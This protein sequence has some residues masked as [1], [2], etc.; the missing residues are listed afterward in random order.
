MRICIFTDSFLP[1]CSGVTFAIINQARELMS[2]GHEVA[3]FRPRPNNRSL[4]EEAGTELPLPVYNVPLS[5]SVP[6][7]PK[8]RLGVPTVITS[9]RELRK[10]KPD[11]IHVASEWGCGWEGVLCAKLLGVPVVGT[12]HT[13]FADPGYLK[14]I[15]LPSWRPLCK[16]MW[17]YSTFFYNRCQFV[18]SPSKAV[19]EALTNQGLREPPIQISNGIQPPPEVWQTEIDA[20]RARYPSEG[21]RFVYIGR[22]S[23]EKSLDILLKGFRGV[24]DRHP[25]ATLFIVGNGPYLEEMEPMLDELTLRENVRMLGFVPHDDL[26]EQRIPLI[27]DCFV[28][29]SKTENQ[30][31]S[32]LEAM[33]FGLP[34]V[35]ANAKG[36]PELVTHE[37]NGLL[38]EPDNIDQL[39]SAMCR[40]AE[41]KQLRLSMVAEAKRH[42]SMHALPHVADQLEDIYRLAIARVK[43]IDAMPNAGPNQP[44]VKTTKNSQGKKVMPA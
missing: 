33:S 19:K 40:V 18:I 8:L 28:T 21:P 35:A 29:A 25:K 16:F 24:V 12:F 27:G 22:V 17:W 15:G 20:V 42:A 26:I 41:D 10:L 36:N 31:V 30:P 44:H 3:V 2:R 9:L 34:V 1:Y 7:V 43:G 13:F 5:I 38:F 6:R 37:E 39:T 4:R 23:P 11:V 14:A 32:I